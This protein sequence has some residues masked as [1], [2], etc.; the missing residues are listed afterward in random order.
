MRP[1]DLLSS[2]HRSIEVVL[3]C[4]ERIAQRARR[5]RILDCD[6]ARE[7]LQFLRTFADGWHHGK[8]EQHLFP[9][10]AAHGLSSHA[11]PVAVM[12]TDHDAGRALLCDIETAL[13]EQQAGSATAPAKF[14]E[15]AC[16]Y[17]ELLRAHIAREDL[18]LFPMAASML[19]AAEQQL[20]SAG[21]ETV[22]RHLPAGTQLAMQGIARSLAARY[23]VAS[24]TGAAESAVN[25]CCHGAAAA[26]GHDREGTSCGAVRTTA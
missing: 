10:L 16:D 15:R 25:S 21:F 13:A 3:D 18:V 23:G 1:T 17:V 22:E 7:A 5:D 24:A 12:L 26:A 8:E 4:L 14:A 20:V 11:G 6:S 2:E 19:T 9:A